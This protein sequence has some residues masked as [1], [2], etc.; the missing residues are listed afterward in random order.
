VYPCQPGASQQ[1]WY[2]TG[3]DRI[4]VTGG[5]QCLDRKSGTNDIQTWQCS[6]G[7]TNQVFSTTDSPPADTVCVQGQ[8]RIAFPPEGADL[9]ALVRAS[10]RAAT[11]RFQ[12]CSEHWFRQ[13]SNKIAVSSTNHPSPH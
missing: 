9:T 10:G 6:S 7:N 12:Y 4:A 1:R 13:S 5:N 11:F 8:Q 2:L 3:D